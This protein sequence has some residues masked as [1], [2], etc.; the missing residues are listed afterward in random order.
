MLLIDFV[1][2]FGKKVFYTIENMNN[3]EWIEEIK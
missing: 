1:F 3:M 2:I